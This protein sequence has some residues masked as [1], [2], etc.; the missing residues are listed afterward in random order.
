MKALVTGGAGLIGSH[1]VD[2]LLK[3][4][5]E[6]R[7]LDNLEKSV[8]HGR[9]PDWIPRDAEFIKGDIINEVDVEKA[10]RDVNIIFHQAA[11]GG[12][13]S[14]IARYFHINV[15]GTA[16]IMQL[17]I[18]GKYPVEKV[19]VASSQAVFGEG[20]YQCPEHGLIHPDLRSLEQMS[21]QDWEVRCPVCSRQMS[22][23]PT[24]EY[25]LNPKTPYAM[26]K[27]T[28]EDMSVKIGAAHGLPT[29]ALRYSVTYGP[30]Q[31]IF[32]PYTGVCSI[33]STRILNDLPTIIYEDGLQTR[34]FI[35]VGDVARANLV[36]AES[37]EANFQVFN[38]GTGKA[39][40]VLD[41]VRLLA[42]TYG[43]E[44]Q[45]ELKGKFRYGDVRH[46]FADNTKFCRLGWQP[47]VTLAEGMDLYAQWIISQGPVKDY[48]SEAEVILKQTKVVRESVPSEVV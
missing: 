44:F 5:Y 13:T 20:M 22:P 43:K 19:V 17:A 15:V 48:F 1:I 2:L 40:S 11:F 47:Q 18:S 27:F 39:T 10:M 24:D 4:G 36:A 46:L 30:R 33:F 25:Q 28:E 16:I 34:D 38:V 7:I 9:K 8:H 45:V 32:N 29:V 14:D 23:R 26:S 3:K 35:Y 37:D 6:V 21:R 42:S 12:F 41:F 31:S